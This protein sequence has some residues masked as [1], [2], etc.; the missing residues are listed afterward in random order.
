MRPNMI[1]RRLPLAF[2]ILALSAT[3]TLAQSSSPTVSYPQGYAVS[4]RLSDIHDNPKPGS[5]ALKVFARRPLSWHTGPAGD[6]NA[7]DRALQKAAGH[8]LRVRENPNFPG[9]GENGYIPGD[10]N[11]AVGPNHI[12]QVVNSEIAIFDKNGNIYSGYPKRLGSVWNNLGGPCAN[13]SGDPVAQYDKLADRFIISQLGS[14][15]SPYSECIAVSTTNDPTG[16]YY[17]YSYSFGSNLNDYDKIG[18]WPTASNSAYLG[19]YNLFANGSS[20][21]GA[22]LCAYDRTAMLSGAPSPAFVCFTLAN[23]GYLPADLDGSTAPS[24]GSPA[25]FMSFDTTSS[26][27]MYELA[28]NFTNPASSTLTRLSDISVASFSEACG[29]GTCVPQPGTGELLD[30]L[31]DRLM[32]RLAYRKFADHEAL[33]ANHSVAVGSTVGVRWYELRR[34]SGSAFTLYQQGTFSP[35]STNRWMGSIAMDQVGDI[36]LGYSTSSSTSYPSLTY[37][38]RIPGDPLGTMESESTIQVGSGSQT[39]YSRWGDYSA[40]RIDPSDDCTFWYTNEYYPVTSSYAWYTAIGSLKFANCTGTADFTISATDPNPTLPS[41]QIGTSMGSVSVTSLNG[42]NSAVALT[43]AGACGGASGITCT[44]NPTS[45]TPAA[46]GAASSNLSVTIASN[47]P[48]GTYPITINGTSGQ[49]SHS[50]S[51]NLVVSAPAPNF[52]MSLSSSSLTIS[53]GSSAKD[54]VT[55]TAQG[56]SSSVTLSIG[57]MPKN[58]SGN[59]K[60]NPITASGNSTLSISV[61]RKASAGSYTLSVTGKNGNFTHS[62]PLGLTIK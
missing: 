7:S 18:V 55:V 51:F 57:T 1:K 45:V 20:F 33:V 31:G 62:V 24:D 41:G 28:P 35:D 21:V 17:L 5:T 49:L 23:G 3:P 50:S 11:I 38:G 8:P 39:G 53:R 9:V 30:S 36:A 44:L 27:S 34:T 25:L 14:L 32:Y 13:N 43:G 12:V 54:T 42:F 16:S 29:G 40:M 26:L 60:P 48:A 19:T 15:S 61:N 56:G 46:G 59:F 2:L 47:T 4:P 6:S 37:T 52:T 22:D 10:P 58:T